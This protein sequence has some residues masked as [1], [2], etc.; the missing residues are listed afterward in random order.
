MPTIR[1]TMSSEAIEELIEQ[2]V[3]D[4]LLTYDANRNNKNENGNGNGSHSD[5]GSGR[6]VGLAQWFEKMESVFHISH[7]AVECH[8]KYDTGT[9][10]DGALTWWNSHVKTFRFE[11][12]YDMSWKDLMK[13]MTE[14]KNK[15][16]LENNPRDNHVQQPPYKRQNV[17]RAYTAEPSENKEYDRNLPL[18]KKCKLHHNGPC[19]I[20]C[21]NCKRVGHLT[22]DCRSIIAAASQ[23]ALEAN[24]RTTITCF[25]CGRQGDYRSDFPKL[26]NQ[27]CGN[28]DGN[29]EARG[30][31]YALGGREAN[32]DPNLVTGM[33]LLN[34]RYASI[35][36]DTGSD[37]SLVSTAFISLIDIIPSALDSKYDVE[38]ADGK[39][40]GVDTILRGCTLNF[41]NHSFNIDLMLMELA[42]FDVIIGVT[43]EEGQI[44]YHIVYQDPEVF[45]ER[46][47][48]LSS[49]HHKEEDEGE[50]GGEA[51]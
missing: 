50:V 30:R 31:V 17:A 14:A 43:V 47:S 28:A 44:E 48:R 16:R 19:I 8:V 3:A 13:M 22:R 35:L 23:K 46:M 26:K 21:G 15:R 49:T 38:L 34:N 5:E 10:L 4:V 37:R 6:A 42:S 45:E 25:M 41:I 11:V 20:K 27:N 36:F 2:Q 18:C 32:Q 9:L 1:Q 7:Y 12:A 39:I 33:F 40:I 29:G 24:Q 51:T